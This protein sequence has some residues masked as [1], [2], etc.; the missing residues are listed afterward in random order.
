MGLVAL[1]FGSPAVGQQAAGSADKISALIVD[2]P[3][4]RARQQTTLK[5]LTPGPSPEGRGE[6]IQ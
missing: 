2:G 4:N 1:A 5:A 3:N 6:I